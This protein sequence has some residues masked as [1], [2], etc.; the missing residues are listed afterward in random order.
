MERR[1]R[2]YHFSSV[3]LSI[4]DDLL[5]RSTPPSSAKDD[6]SVQKSAI[7]NDHFVGAVG[8]GVLLE[9]AGASVPKA[10]GVLSR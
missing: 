4:T 3:A 5:H 6:L 8:A 9:G 10:A 2:P 7:P 1:T